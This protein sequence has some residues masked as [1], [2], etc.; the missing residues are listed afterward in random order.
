MDGMS[1]DPDG[2][3]LLWLA[4][5]FVVVTVASRLVLTTVWP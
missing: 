3:P 1:N 4:C 5:A 2:P